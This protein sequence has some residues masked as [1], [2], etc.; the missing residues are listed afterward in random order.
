[1]NKNPEISDWQRYIRDNVHTVRAEQNLE[2]IYE[3]Q[4]R[5]IIGRPQESDTNEARICRFD[6]KSRHEHSLATYDEICNRVRAL[7]ST[8]R[9]LLR[10]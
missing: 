2:G 3:P 10:S 5:V 1:M 4:G 7:A 8:L 9:T 6:M